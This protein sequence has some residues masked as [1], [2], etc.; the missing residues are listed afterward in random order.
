MKKKF[1]GYKGEKKEEMLLRLYWNQRSLLRKENISKYINYHSS[2]KKRDS[3][4]M[5]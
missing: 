1:N 4:A 2:K 5:V 3:I